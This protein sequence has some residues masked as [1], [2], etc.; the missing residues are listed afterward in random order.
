MREGPPRRV[1]S[2]ASRD[3]VETC[4]QPQVKDSISQVNGILK[5]WP[6]GSNKLGNTMRS[7]DTAAR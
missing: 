6:I 4:C 2:P 5:G 7:L 1:I 3:H